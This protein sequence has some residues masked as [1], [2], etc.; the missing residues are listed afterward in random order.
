[1]VNIVTARKLFLSWDRS[2]MNYKLFPVPNIYYISIENAYSYFNFRAVE[3]TNITVFPLNLTS[4]YMVFVSTYVPCSGLHQRNSAILQGITGC[5][6]SSSIEIV[7]SCGHPTPP[8]RGWLGH[9]QS[10]TPHST[11]T[12][13]YDSGWWPSEQF[14][15]ACTDQLEWVPDPA[16]HTCSGTVCN[17][18]DLA[19]I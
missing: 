15:A 16:N 6:L 11:V 10:T 4:A 7:G 8:L 12:F 13:Q 9:Y 3:T 14:T 19:Y 5:R 17:A 2:R 18:P 1:M